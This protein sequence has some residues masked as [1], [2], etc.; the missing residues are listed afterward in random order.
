MTRAL[1]SFSME[2]DGV[3]ILA[4]LLGVEPK[5]ISSSINRRPRYFR[6]AKPK[7]PE[8]TKF[9][10]LHIPQGSTAELQ[11]A[12]F[13]RL[14]PLLRPSDAA[15]A[16]TSG[17]GVHT[18]VAPHTHSTPFLY[19]DFSDAFGSVSIRMLTDAIAEE[20]RSSAALQEIEEIEGE[21]LRDSAHFWGCSA[22]DLVEAEF[23]EQGLIHEIAKVI[24]AL[25]ILEKGG[26][27]QGTQ[28]SPLLLNIVAKRMDEALLRFC[29]KRGLSYTRYSDDLV[30]S[31]PEAIPYED[32][33]RIRQ[34]VKRH[35]FRVNWEKSHYSQG[36]A[37]EPR[38]MGIVLKGTYCEDGSLDGERKKSLSRR[39]VEQY[40]TMIHR[41]T[42]DPESSSEQIRGVLSWCIAV[43]DG[44]IPTRLKGPFR[45]Y[46]RMRDRAGLAKYQ[47]YLTV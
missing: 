37:S 2:N 39:K 27:P 29:K 8:A 9:R 18:C 28:T 44:A 46:F 25:T 10:V 43:Y 21:H 47:N 45:K 1:W 20:L 11:A 33:R 24:A 23:Q 34:I 32:R 7:N 36:R 17:R 12:L 6:V 5:E 3:R 40:R 16:Y 30:I 14:F 15:H 38:L 13:E 19:I 35:G 22:A 4:A 42:W 31:S 41:A 26:L